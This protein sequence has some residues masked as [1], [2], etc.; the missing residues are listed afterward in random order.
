MNKE[1][2]EQVDKRWGEE[3]WFVNDGYCGK[4]LVL[5]KNAECS[6]HAHLVKK[7]TFMCIE[8]YAELTVEGKTYM[9]APFTRAK[10][11]NPGEKHKLRGITAAVI[12]EVSTRHDDNDVVRFSESKVGFSDEV[13]YGKEA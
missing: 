7:E 12:V 5:D 11:I 13:K 3:I 10:T 4:F 9:M 2:L 6:Y 1:P 8:G